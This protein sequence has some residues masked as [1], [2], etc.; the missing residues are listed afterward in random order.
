MPFL[1]IGKD[2][3]GDTDKKRMDTVIPVSVGI[4]VIQ[5]TKFGRYL[6]VSIDSKMSFLSS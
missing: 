1:S 2:R 5:A 6:E 3:G 4:D